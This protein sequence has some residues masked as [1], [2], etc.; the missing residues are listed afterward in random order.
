MTP[1]PGT[2]VP[3]AARASRT[4]IAEKPL[5]SFVCAKPTK[6]R[7]ALR[8]DA[9]LGA[10]GRVPVPVPVPSSAR[11]DSRRSPLSSSSSS[12][13][14]TTDCRSSRR[15]PRNAAELDAPD[16]PD[17]ETR[18]RSTPSR[19]WCSFPTRVPSPGATPRLSSPPSSSRSSS[20]SM[21]RRPPR[22]SLRFL[23]CLCRSA[24]AADSARSESSPRNPSP[25]STIAR[26]ASNA[27]ATRFTPF[28][29]RISRGG[30]RGGSS[31]APRGSA[32]QSTDPPRDANAFS[33]ASARKTRVARVDRAAASFD[34]ATMVSHAAV[35]SRFASRTRAIVAFV[36][37]ASFPRVKSPTSSP[38]RFPFR[39]FERADEAF[40]VVVFGSRPASVRVRT[41]VRARGAAV[42][43]ATRNPSATF[44]RHRRSFD[45]TFAIAEESATVSSTRRR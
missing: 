15:R 11:R 44:A 7:R 6:P 39:A 24:S 13:Q 8:R 34:R 43:A 14:S 25:P 29:S 26:A 1:S 2:L 10:A 22:V 27:R 19:D 30:S 16:V 23:L 18:R 36:A 21:T 4:S 35:A 38:R 41:R 28:A 9:L 45:S 33:R 42:R 20:S 40:D 5:A 32:D 12:I 3:G 37:D 17:D 31:R